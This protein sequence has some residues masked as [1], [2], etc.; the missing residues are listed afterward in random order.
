MAIRL[1]NPM[2]GSPSFQSEGLIM[3][4]FLLLIVLLAACRNPVGQ[5]SPFAGD[6]SFGYEGT[7]TG[8]Y[9]VQ[10]LPARAPMPEWRHGTFAV[11][12]HHPSDQDRLMIL[13]NHDFG[14]HRDA[15]FLDV[16]LPIHPGV[17]F[18]MGA[19]NFRMS[20]R[21]PWDG[22]VVNVVGEVHIDEVAR[23]RMRG[24]FHGTG[25]GPVNPATGVGDS[26]RIFD[27]RFDIPILP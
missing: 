6:L 23:G 27:G 24:T 10:G 13:A 8:T 20:K 7:I 16:D 17:H 1:L 4:L 11:A 2:L 26:V 25:F 12:A 5:E 22:F 18:A 15:L 14:E 9:H 21:E 19:L 3:R